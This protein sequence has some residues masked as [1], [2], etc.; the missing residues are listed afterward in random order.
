M[1]CVSRCGEHLPFLKNHPGERKRGMSDTSSTVLGVV[2]DCGDGWANG[3]RD[4]LQ[5]LIEQLLIFLNAYH[6]TGEQP[7]ACACLSIRT[8]SSAC[9]QHECGPRCS[10]ET[11]QPTRLARVGRQRTTQPRSASTGGTGSGRERSGGGA[12]VA[13]PL[14]SAAFA[15]AL[16]RLERA[17]RLRIKV[18]PRLLLIHASPDSPSQHLASMNCV[19]AAQ[20]LGILIDTV[21]LARGDDSMVLQQAAHL[22]GGLHLRPDEPTL[23][24]LSQYL[25]T[26]CLPSR[27][28]RQFLCCRGSAGPRR[29]RFAFSARTPWR[30]AMRAPCASRSFAMITS[31]HAPSVARV[32]LSPYRRGKSS[33]KRLQHPNR[34]RP[35]AEELA[36][37]ADEK[38]GGLGRPYLK[39]LIYITERS[40]RI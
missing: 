2:I 19:F 14:L 18:E 17:R 25:I 22:T 7:A 37:R 9:G 10:G 28:A 16:C 39:Y 21:S 40:E 30:L 27:Q 8:R 23:R 29:A 3:R 4:E 15:T 33:K 24:G 1:A 35:R 20:K 31:M 6:L 32:S 13:P 26:H 34:R 36:L 11:M 12:G 38:S 5:S